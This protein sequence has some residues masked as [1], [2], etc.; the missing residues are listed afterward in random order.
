MGVIGILRD[1]SAQKRGELRIQEEIRRRD[2]FLAMLSHEL[3][4]PLGAVVTATAL[5][6]RPDCDDERRPRLV[7]IVERQSQ[8]MARLLD[9]LLEVSRVTQSKIELRKQRLDL[10]TVAREAA[11]AVRNL[12]ESRKIAFSIAIDPE[13]IWVIGDP[14]RLQ[15][16]QVNLLHNAAKYTHRGGTVKLAVRREEVHAVLSVIDDGAGIPKEMLNDVFALFVQSKRTLDRS[17]G[18]LGVGLTL[19]RSLVAMHGGAVTARSDGDGRGS[20]FVVR[21]PLTSAPVDEEPAPS[22]E[23]IHVAG[24][25][26]V[27]GKHVVVVEDNADAREMLCELL[28]RAGFDCKSADRGDAGLDLI[29][30]LRPD[31]AL[32]DVGLP[33]IDG[34]ELAR[35]VRADHALDDVYLVALTGYG[36]ATD[37]LTATNAGF[38]EH[39]VKPVRSDELIRLLTQVEAHDVAGASGGRRSAG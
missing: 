17:E 3:R 16:I 1:V 12:M 22:R 8:Q 38:D 26:R 11:E 20:E 4:N 39:V 36:Q 25:R 15:Q 18:G 27:K 2:E 7:E 35:R 33:V 30:D 14:A 13:P 21:L 6:K 23:I 37:R 29:R 19:V 24:R 31:V 10:S 28:T 32:V 9:D 5:L 34:L